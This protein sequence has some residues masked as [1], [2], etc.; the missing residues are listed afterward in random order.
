M[1]LSCCMVVCWAGMRGQ[2][3]Y[4]NVQQAPR[5]TV[6]PSTGLVGASAA[7]GKPFI[8]QARLKSPQFQ[9]PEA[10]EQR[11]ACI[12]YEVG[13]KPARELFGLRAADTVAAGFFVTTGEYTGAARAFADG[14]RLTLVDG[15]DFVRRC[16]ELPA[17]V[18]ARL[19]S[20]A[21]AGDYRRPPVPGA[22]RR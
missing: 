16:A 5:F 8:R 11:K 2:T 17:D 18:Q 12:S 19:H 15:A 9:R 14:K 4:T 13:V 21:T 7:P 22:A 20:T 6:G 10:V 3:R 1:A